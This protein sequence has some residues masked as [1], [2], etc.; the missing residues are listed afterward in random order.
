MTA[1][2]RLYCCA[3]DCGGRPCG[4]ERF[5]SDAEAIAAGWVQ[6]DPDEYVDLWVCDSHATDEE[7]AAQERRLQPAEHPPEVADPARE[8]DG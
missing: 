5:G 8:L 6:R 1:A 7:R 4:C 2:G 3:E